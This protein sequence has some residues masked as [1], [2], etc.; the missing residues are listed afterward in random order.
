MV[1][2]RKNAAQ[3]V[4]MADVA[5]QAGVSLVTVSR[6]VNNHEYVAEDT[7][8][9]VL[10]V[11]EQLGFQPNS[12]ARSLVSKH[13][14]T[15]GLV[16]TDLGD[17]SFAQTISGAELE[18]ARQNYF[19]LL[20]STEG[21]ADN[22]PQYVRLF[23]ERYVDGLFFVR[24][25]TDIFDERLLRL[26]DGG[27]PIVTVSYHLPLENVRVVDIDNV[28]GAQQAVGHLIELGHRR[29]AMLTGP[30]EYKSVRDRN[31][32][33]ALTLEAARVPYDESL[34]VEG[35][36]SYEGGYEAMKVLLGR[37]V[38]FSALFAQS[39]EIAIGAMQAFRE[40]GLRIPEDASMVAYNDNRVAA[41]LDPALTTVRQ[42]MCE[43]GQLGIQLLVR[44]INGEVLEQR[45]FLLRP[46]LIIRASTK[47]A[48]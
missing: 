46:Q 48:P 23:K 7:R 42:A 45:E 20:A 18:A 12:I 11:I 14:R 32:G 35:K 5:R 24:P 13:T 40:A 9:H 43:I 15:I 6:V 25:S 27:I 10:H 21:I 17:Y 44:A 34:I 19:C 4:T 47:P 30:S 36:W 41:Y 28:D 38:S 31:H 2:K 33:Y 39:D 8:A 3:S 26:L 29:I 37:G 22:E 16:T 1:K